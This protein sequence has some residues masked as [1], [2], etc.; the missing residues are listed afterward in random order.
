MCLV[1]NQAGYSNSNSAL[2]TSMPTNWPSV[3]NRTWFQ[4]GLLILIGLQAFFANIQSSLFGETEGLYANV[5]HHMIGGGNYFYI[6]MPEGPYFNKPPLF[7]WVQAALVNGLG[8]SEAALRFPSALA[9]LGTMMVT[10]FFG[11]LLFSGVA[12]FFAAV[13][14]CTCYAGLWFGSLGIIDPVLTFFM[15]LGLYSW[16]KAYFEQN[17]RWWYVVG[18]VALSF[19]TMAKSFH[20]VAL[21]ALVFGLFLWTQ[22]DAG[23][24]RS[25][26]FWYGVMACAILL[27][28]YFLLLSQEFR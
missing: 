21:P 23:P 22:R 26:E 1:L 5:T 11:R 20:G 15:T 18:F 17:S 3:F 7:F 27:T 24:L 8:W 6:T 25:R 13:V 14:V 12:G 19:G 28:G 4:L 16:V 2:N 9:S 10:Y